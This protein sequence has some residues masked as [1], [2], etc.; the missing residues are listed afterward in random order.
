MTV[1]CVV[2]ASVLVVWSLVMACG[3]FEFKYMVV[4]T[5]KRIESNLAAIV[6]RLDALEAKMAVE[7]ENLKAAVAEQTTVIDSAV[8]LLTQLGDK[9]DELKNDP[10]EL[11][12][13]ANQIRAKRDQLAAAV[14]E[15]TPA[16]EPP[17]EEPPTEEPPTEPPTEEPPAN[18]PPA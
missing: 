11:T 17:P 2:V 10:Q 18:P 7:L 14:A 12:N 15:N 8:T 3:S 13:L 6:S 16:E 1:F 5:L 4:E 9:I